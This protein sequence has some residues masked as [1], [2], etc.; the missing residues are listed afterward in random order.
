MKT[1]GAMTGQPWKARSMSITAVMTT[2]YWHLSGFDAETIAATARKE[3][4]VENLI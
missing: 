2:S 1:L 4:R 3:E